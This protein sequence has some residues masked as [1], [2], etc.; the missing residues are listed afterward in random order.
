MGAIKVASVMVLGVVL[1]V[2]LY[3]EPTLRKMSGAEYDEYCR[4]V[5]RWVPWMR[6]W[7]R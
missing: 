6:A 2:L 3:E 4:N 1:F 7:D 5:R